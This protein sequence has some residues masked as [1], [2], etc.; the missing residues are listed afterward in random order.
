MPIKF[1]VLAI[2]SAFTAGTVHWGCQTDTPATQQ[3]KAAFAGS[4]QTAAPVNMAS[5][6]SEDYLL[7]KFDP[8][9]H[10]DFETV[11]MPYSDRAGMAMRREAFESFK[12][13]HENNDDQSLIPDVFEDEKKEEQ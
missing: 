2:L 12:K 8:A 6:V 3:A 9:K 5:E 7:G 10:P 1:F 13:M 4:T 11:G